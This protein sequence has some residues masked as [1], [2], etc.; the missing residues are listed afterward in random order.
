MELRY[1]Y[2]DPLAYFCHVG[3]FSNAFSRLLWKTGKCNIGKSTYMISLFFIQKRIAAWTAPIVFLLAF[4]AHI[5]DNGCVDSDT[6][7]VSAHPRLSD[8]HRITVE[9]HD[10]TAAPC[11]PSRTRTV[12]PILPTDVPIAW[13]TLE[14]VLYLLSPLMNVPVD[15]APFSTGK[16]DSFLWVHFSFI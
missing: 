14:A 13:T 4:Q 10:I 3:L 8:W 1:K 16:R 9:V 7:T 12:L 15:G 11:R 5:K 6:D 2:K